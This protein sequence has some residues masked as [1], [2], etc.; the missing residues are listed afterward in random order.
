[1]HP[2]VGGENYTIRIG[3]H[4]TGVTYQNRCFIAGING[5]PIVG[6]TTVVIDAVTHQ[7][8]TLVSSLR[9][10]ENIKDLGDESAT[11]YKLRPVTFNFKTDSTKTKQFGLIAEE[12][13][14]HMPDLVVKNEEGQCEAVKYTELPVLLLNELQKQKKELDEYRSALKNTRD[15][16]RILEEQVSLLLQKKGEL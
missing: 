15:R 2:G 7:L 1:M 10:K 5:N 14:E 13:I 12:V 4:G 3:Q 16:L 11:I 6:G 8:G 9:Y